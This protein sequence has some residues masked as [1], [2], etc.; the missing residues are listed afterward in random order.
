MTTVAGGRLAVVD[1]ELGDSFMTDI[2]EELARLADLKD[3]GVLTEAE[4]D[5]Q[6]ALLLHPAAAATAA[7]AAAAVAPA[8]VAPPYAPPPRQA[9]SVVPVLIVVGVLV[10]L[11]LAG[12]LLWASGLLGRVGH[13]S[14]QTV[15]AVS[16]AP[17]AP[18]SSAI[19]APPALPVAPVPAPA[20]AQVTANPLLGQWVSDSGGG[21]NCGGGLTFADTTVTIS[22]PDGNGGMKEETDPLT[23]VVLSPTSVTLYPGKNPGESKVIELVDGHFML[24]SC[25]F[26]R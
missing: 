19:I 11:V 3:R 15:A 1:N 25:L 9:G 18:A 7:P 5:E 23:Y 26:H 22:Q 24:E 6:K 12:G 2:T 16:S 20:V 13:S 8:P 17:V 14:A 4:F 10:V 21:S